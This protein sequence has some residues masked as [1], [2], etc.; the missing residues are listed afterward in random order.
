MNPNK[1]E[2]QTETLTDEQ[3]KLI[4][5][6]MANV[7]AALNEIDPTIAK[8]IRDQ[9][10]DIAECRRMAMTSDALDIRYLGKVGVSLKRSKL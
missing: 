2:L 5:D 4:A 8:R 6:T 10:H 1:M 3:I 7:E 9:Q